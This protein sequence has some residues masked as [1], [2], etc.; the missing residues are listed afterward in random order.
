[1]GSGTNHAQGV[2]LGEP[3]WLVARPQVDLTLV[4]LGLGLFERDMNAMAIGRIL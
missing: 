1:M 2:D 3:T 4:V